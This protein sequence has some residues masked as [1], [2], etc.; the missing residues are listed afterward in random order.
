[1]ETYVQKIKLKKGSEE[2]VK[3]WAHYFKKNHD[4]V[5]QLIQNEG[6]LVE[7]AFLDKDGDNT[8][9]FY[10]MKVKDRAKMREVFQKSDDPI[11]VY[12]KNFMNEVI[13]ETYEMKPLIDFYS[14]E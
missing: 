10:Y 2:K 5:K 7:S 6:V 4:K 1:M 13:D 11:D 8:Y 9:L 14:I 12:H 3:E